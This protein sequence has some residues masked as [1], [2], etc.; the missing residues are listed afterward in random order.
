MNSRLIQCIYCREI[1]PSSKEH[2]LQAGLG[3]NLT[4]QL[5][6]VKCNS[7]FSAIDQSLGESSLLALS[8]VGE[9]K[10]DGMPVQLGG[11]HFHQDEKG[12]WVEAKVINGF[13]VVFFPQIHMM[14]E[15]E[16]GAELA[17]VGSEA[18][19]LKDFISLVGQRIADGSIESTHIKLGPEEKCTTPRIVGHRRN[20]F[21]IR[22]KTQAEGLRF[23]GILKAAWGQISAQ[24]NGASL[25]AEQIPSPGIQLNLRIRPND[26]H[27][28][29]A[30]FAFNYLA[31]CQGP[32]FVMR[33]E[34]DPLRKY[35]RGIEV[36]HE[37]GL[38]DGEVAVDTRFV[39]MLPTGAI[40]LIATGQHAIALTCPESQLIALLTLYQQFSFIV[41][42][43]EI[44]LEEP[45]V[46]AHEFSTDK[47]SNHAL[48]LEELG[49]RILE[50]QGITRT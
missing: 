43:A 10:T 41:I 26:N 3:G 15:A 34:F 27:R 6:C 4:T 38:K 49:R 42:M 5:V 36:L 21:F 45:L 30:K 44:H 33:S 13:Q 9:A 24:F 8:R 32:E 22:A 39:R 48:G 25:T 7:A 18:P 17:F 19:A 37:G 2:I 1:G 16:E 23:L 20:D 35:I 50:A 40:P 12:R 28:A 11:E 29:V 47:S 31:H 14:S 46:H